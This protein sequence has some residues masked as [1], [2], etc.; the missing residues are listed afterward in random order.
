[1]S[2]CFLHVNYILYI[3][4][5]NGDVPDDQVKHFSFVFATSFTH[6]LQ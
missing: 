5:M 2:I 3:V 4:L 6:S 1:M